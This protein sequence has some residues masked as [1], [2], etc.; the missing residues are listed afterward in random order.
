M[1]LEKSKASI[2]M[3]IGEEKSMFWMLHL[4]S[5]QILTL[6]IT[7]SVEMEQWMHVYLSKSISMTLVSRE[8]GC[9]EQEIR[10]NIRNLWLTTLG[11]K[12]FQNTQQLMMKEHYREAPSGWIRKPS[13]GTWCVSLWEGE[14]RENWWHFDQLGKKRLAVIVQYKHI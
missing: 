12:T 13:E 6:W 3:I 8:P 7:G 4:P 11:E 14:R 1:Q 5:S 9:W 10:Q 2:I